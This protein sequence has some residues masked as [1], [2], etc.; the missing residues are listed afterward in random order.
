M[1]LGVRRLSQLPLLR[2]EIQI[3]SL[4][5]YDLVR[6]C[7]RQQL[8]LHPAAQASVEAYKTGN[9]RPVQRR[10]A[11]LSALNHLLQRDQRQVA[12]NVLMSRMRGPSQNRSDAASRSSGAYAIVDIACAIA[13]IRSE[14]SASYGE[15]RRAV[16]TLNGL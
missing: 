1:L 15:I 10:R 2:L 14:A 4:R 7:E 16:M 11:A 5:G 13:D 12:G 6:P 8:A 9:R 3:S